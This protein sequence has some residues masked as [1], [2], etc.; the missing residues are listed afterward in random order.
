MAVRPGKGAGD[1]A[2][3]KSSNAAMGR[4][5]ASNASLVSRTWFQVF[6][7]YAVGLSA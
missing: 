1:A 3:P 4:P 5:A 6:F 7:R 2:R